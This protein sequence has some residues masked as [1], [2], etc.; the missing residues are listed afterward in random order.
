MKVYYSNYK[1]TETGLPCFKRLCVKE[2]E[3]GFRVYME[4]D[5]GFGEGSVL[6]LV[7]T[8]KKYKTRSGAIKAMLSWEPKKYIMTVAEGLMQEGK[9]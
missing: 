2:C 8:I 4:T 9:I 5:R 6:S 3:E 7:S 1:N